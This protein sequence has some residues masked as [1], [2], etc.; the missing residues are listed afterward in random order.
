MLSAGW[1]LATI[2]CKRELKSTNDRRKMRERLLQE[3]VWAKR[4]PQLV[5]DLAATVFTGGEQAHAQMADNSQAIRINPN[6]AAALR[7]RFFD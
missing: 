4:S 2:G 1:V 5:T 3:L 7:L 6:L